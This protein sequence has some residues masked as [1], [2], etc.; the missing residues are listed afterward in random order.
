M[1]NGEAAKE[2]EAEASASIKVGLRSN[3]NRSIALSRQLWEGMVLKSSGPPSWETKPEL[4]SVITAMIARTR[5]SDGVRRHRNRAVSVPTVG[6][7]L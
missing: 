5:T 3:E 4:S 1:R 7:W 6:V 2:K